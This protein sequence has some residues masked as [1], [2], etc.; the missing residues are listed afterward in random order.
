MDSS[1][2]NMVSNIGRYRAARN[3]A[4]ARMSFFGA[5]LLHDGARLEAIH[6]WVFCQPH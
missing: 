2:Y 5:L 3:R 4:A 6:R 1:V